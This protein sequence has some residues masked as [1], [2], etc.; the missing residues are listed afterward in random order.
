MK[1]LT[2]KNAT[3]TQ[4]L[5]G[6]LASVLNA[7]HLENICLCLNGTLGV[8]K[9]CFS[10]GFAEGLNVVDDV[11]SPTFAIVHEYSGD[12]DILH[13]D[14]YR[15]EKEDLPNLALDEMIEDHIG[16]VLIEWADKHPDI[17]PNSNLVIEILFDD[18]WRLWNCWSNGQ[19][20]ELSF[21]LEQFYN[22]CIEEGFEHRKNLK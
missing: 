6:I 3:E 14:L 1:Q 4:K 9:T 10:Q 11:L 19:N 22:K 15:L 16:I 7:T 8:G 20:P 17:I 21:A 13:M 2:T 5:A 18:D 12:R